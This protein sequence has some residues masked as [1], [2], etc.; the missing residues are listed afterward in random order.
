MCVTLNNENNGKCEVLPLRKAYH[1]TIFKNEIYLHSST[2][3]VSVNKYTC[4]VLILGNCE[5]LPLRKSYHITIFKNEICLYSSTYYISVN[6]YTCLV[7]K[8]IIPYNQEPRGTYRYTRIPGHEYISLQQY[9]SNIYMTRTLNSLAVPAVSL[10]GC[11]ILRPFF[12][13]DRYNERYVIV[14]LGLLLVVLLCL[15]SSEV[16][17]LLCS[18]IKAVLSQ[19]LRQFT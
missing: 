4:L 7:L 19:P 13:S 6:E 3:S 1:I 15:Q 2:Y 10:T 18:K 9:N 12:Y 8:T 11:V 5:V 14:S 17:S 16:G